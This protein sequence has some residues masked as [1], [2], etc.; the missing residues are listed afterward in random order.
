M[1]NKESL[2]IVLASFLLSCSNTKIN[3][4]QDLFVN[5]AIRCELSEGA[6]PL[7][8]FPH[9]AD[10][11]ATDSQ[12]QDFCSRMSKTFNDAEPIQNEEAERIF[13]LVDSLQLVNDEMQSPD[14]KRQ[15]DGLKM[16]RE[17]TKIKKLGE[18]QYLIYYYYFG[19]GTNYELRL[20][21]LKDDGLQKS[22]LLESWSSHVPC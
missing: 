2:F 13:Y 17:R 15:D 14:D 5:E 9:T 20:I 21:T 16:A 1:M 18:S 10:P 12:F 11:Q 22:E 6:I 7:Q 4:D 3:K 8:Q 19:C